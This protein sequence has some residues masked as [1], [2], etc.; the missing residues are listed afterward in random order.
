M[1]KSFSIWLTLMLSIS[2]WCGDVNPAEIVATHNSVRAEVGVPSITYSAEVAASAQSWADHLKSTNNCKMTHSN[3][4]NGENLFWAGGWSN[5]PAQDIRS[6][7]PVSAWANEKRD[8]DHG[9]NECAVGKVCG[10]YTQL[11]W[12]NSTQVGCGMAMCPNNDQ[13]WVCQYAPAGN[14]VGQKPY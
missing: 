1:K 4:S 14:W 10:H 8:Y 9:K 7:D 3:G 11:V 12:K 2:A 5:G 6:A 13:V